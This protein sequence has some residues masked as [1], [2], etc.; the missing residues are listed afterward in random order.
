MQIT[1][2]SQSM[3]VSLAFIFLGFTTLF[4][5]NMLLS[6]GD[7]T[8][9]EWVFKN[10]SNAQFSYGGAICL[11]ILILC[12]TRFKLS[13]KS[14]IGCLVLGL[15]LGTFAC[16]CFLAKI[17]TAGNIWPMYMISSLIGVGSAFIQG[18][19]AGLATKY[20]ENAMGKFS[21]GQAIAGLSCLPI[22]LGLDALGKV[23]YASNS[24]PATPIAPAV[25]FKIA[26]FRS[27][28]FC[29][30]ACLTAIATHFV[31]S[32][33]RKKI[34][35]KTPD[36]VNDIEMKGISITRGYLGIIKVVFNMS[37]MIFVNF[38]FTFLVFPSHLSD[39]WDKDQKIFPVNQATIIYLFIFN[40]FDFIGKLLV[41]CGLK[42]TR[43]G[44]YACTLIRLPLMVAFYFASFASNNIVTHEIFKMGLIALFASLQGLVVTWCFILAPNNKLKNNEEYERA[45]NVNVFALTLG[46]F[47]AS[48]IT[49][50]GKSN[51]YIED[52]FF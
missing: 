43:T 52:N 27:T 48:T 15:A 30:F 25:L 4:A 39:H 11:F 47:I 29:V 12:F 40:L 19:Y 7:F 51:A 9:T 1:N 21:M 41:T 20:S 24:T 50:F 5:W 10:A 44:V 14:L 6:I 28:I 33:L 2:L 22:G 17:G 36:S 34:N 31:Y 26:Q 35:S 13:I 37:F 46:I 42:L 18:T 38:I 45:G 16:F 3:L 23:I 8:K 49:V 32:W